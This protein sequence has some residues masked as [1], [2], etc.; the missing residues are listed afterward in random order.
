LTAE[1]ISNF[2]GQCHRTWD[3]IAS[4]GPQGIGNVRF[5]PYRLTNSK[6][7]DTEDKR[8]SCIAC[9]DP[10]Q[11]V[12]QDIRSYD[13]KCLGCHAGKQAKAKG[14]PVEKQNCVSCHMPKLELPGA[15]FKFTD[16]EIRVVK[17]EYPD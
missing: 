15:H 4:H 13:S 7:Y 16:H 8:I 10:H 1:E 3:E 5:Q 11:E 6:C 17:G 12:V 9:H 14:C 2:C